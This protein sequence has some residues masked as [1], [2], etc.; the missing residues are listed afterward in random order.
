MVA[1]LNS[2]EE[3]LFAKKELGK[4]SVEQ[5]ITL[6][7]FKEQVWKELVEPKKDEL[8]ERIESID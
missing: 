4:I 7:E 6:G 3:K 1:L 2:K 8:K 5:S